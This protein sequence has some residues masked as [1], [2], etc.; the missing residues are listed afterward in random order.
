MDP[1]FARRTAES[2]Q[3]QIRLELDSIPTKHHGVGL[4]PLMSS[5]PLELK[6]MIK[7]FL[8]EHLRIL[9]DKMWYPNQ[10][11]LD[12][13][14]QRL[15]LRQAKEPKEREFVPKIRERHRITRRVQLHD[16]TKPSRFRLASIAVSQLDKRI[17][18][19]Y[20]R[21]QEIFGSEDLDDIAELEE[22]SRK[23]DESLKD[24]QENLDI[25]FTLFANSI[26]VR[27]NRRV[28]FVKREA[29]AAL[30][31]SIG[32]INNSCPTG[33]YICKDKE[34]EYAVLDLKY[35]GND[36]RAFSLYMARK[37]FVVHDPRKL[38]EITE[39][40][41]ARI[42]SP[43]SVPN[44]SRLSA[45]TVF[46]EKLAKC[47]FK[48]HDGYVPK[49][50]NSGKACFEK[51][52][53]Q[54]GKRAAV[55]DL[56]PTF[57]SGMTRALTI[58]SAG[59]PRTINLNSA[60]AE[61]FAF[62]NS[63]MLDKL[64]QCAWLITGRSVEEWAEDC[65][66]EEGLPD[67]H[68]F[69]SGDLKSATDYFNPKIAE[70]VIR[71]LA[72]E[73]QDVGSFEEMVSYITRAAFFEDAGG[74]WVLRCLQKCGQL[75]ASDFSFPILCI[76]S[77]V[78]LVEAHGQLDWALTLRRKD[79]RRFVIEWNNGGVNGDDIV[80]WGREGI[81]K[82]WQM[83][84]GFIGGVPEPSKS[85][86]SKIYF[87]VNSELWKCD[88]HGLKRIDAI[89]PAMLLHVSGGAHKVPHGKWVYLFNSSLMT[90]DAQDIL[91]PDTILYPDLPSKWGGLAQIEPRYD[92]LWCKR[93]MFALKSRSLTIVDLAELHDKSDGIMAKTKS[94]AVVHFGFEREERGVLRCFSGF[95]DRYWLQETLS[96]R[97]SM[98]KLV[99]WSSSSEIE[100]S[101]FSVR[102]QVEKEARDLLKTRFIKR[103]RMSRVFVG[104]TVD[105]T[106]HKLG[107]FKT[108]SLALR[109][110]AL[111]R[112]EKEGLEYVT[113]FKVME[114]D[115][116]MGC[117]LDTSYN[118]LFPVH[119]NNFRIA[120]SDSAVG[121]DEP[122]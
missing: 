82:K 25:A 62:L 43:P 65:V 37:A 106:L 48:R 68:V 94:G 96:T 112:G 60:E 64:K 11:M 53:S 111:L 54:G 100:Q 97:F 24:K 22:L 40:F 114:G 35:E 42:S 104:H 77:F 14:L 27:T 80:T 61:K 59:K 20:A 71:V 74:V 19:L 115:S 116:T 72:T 107:I 32:S 34:G 110:R 16:P 29:D 8:P 86:L 2:R 13:F 99:H 67:G 70:A 30:E 1:L 69:C 108:S 56:N 17:E 103:K 119:K 66:P 55:Y 117:R 85:P 73:F 10:S 33:K 51:S 92:L 109:C 81:E 38:P 101:F 52:R 95:V 15:T 122:Q 118:H 46:V 9:V 57:A 76:C 50:P 39:D 75:M 89:L 36:A 105:T 87:T 3:L 90:K 26:G 45:M 63:F 83:S 31:S 84:V 12:Q 44:P 21:Y 41:Y 58:L 98:N 18:K 120:D 28:S 6:E 102:N 23:L 78:S 47:L 5:L 49:P 113:G 79:F 4:V 91:Q 7:S 88:E 93:A 121:S